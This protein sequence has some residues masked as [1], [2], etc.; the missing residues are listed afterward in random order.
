MKRKLIGV[1]LAGLL[2]I[3]GAT[4][5]LAHGGILGGGPANG[6]SLLSEV[7]DS[8]VSDGTINQGQAD[9][10]EN[11]VDER[12]TLLQEEAQARREQLQGFL[13][14]GTLSADELAQLPE[15]SPL[16]NLDAFLEDGQLAQDELQQ[17]GLLGRGLGHGP[18]GPWGGGPDDTTNG[19][20]DGTSS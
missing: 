20:T 4:A 7:L 11:A 13:E 9:A 17:L 10:I 14:D 5:A 1:P 18:H 8:L 6:T 3:G 19:T 16:H 2:L 12:R 15:D